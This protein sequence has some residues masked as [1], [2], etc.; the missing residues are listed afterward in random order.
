MGTYRIFCRC[1]HRS[2][3]AHWQWQAVGLRPPCGPCNGMN[4][5]PLGQAAEEAAE[6][7]PP[8]RPMCAKC[9]RPQS[10]CICSST[11][12]PLGVLDVSGLPSAP[13][14]LP[15]GLES[16]LLLRHP[17]E[18][19][20]KHQSAWILA[21]CLSGVRQH[22]ARRLPAVGQQAPTGLEHVYEEPK[23]C[24]LVI[25][26]MDA[27]PLRPSAA[28]NNTGTWA[29]GPS[30]SVFGGPKSDASEEMCWMKRLGVRP[31]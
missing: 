9:T 18:R 10:V 27:K 13:L 17:K 7:V 1:V 26:G 24:L 29:F 14:G 23:S 4:V 21:R 28:K 5:G 12:L 31:V 20:Q 8:R 6:E 2:C 22:V 30:S 3:K 15:T 25:P 11:S 19:R 16:V